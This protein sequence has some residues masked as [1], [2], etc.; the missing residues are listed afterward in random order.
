MSASNFAPS[1]AAML[2]HEGGF[3][4]N[5]NDPGG[6]TNQGVT[7]AVY[8]DWRS[9]KG[10]PQRSVRVIGAAE[11]ETIY[12]DL[13]WN[14]I[15]GDDLPSGVDYAVFDFAF[16]SGVGRAARFL[17]QAVGAVP[18]GQIG[19]ATLALVEIKQ[20]DQLIDALCDMRLNFLQ[21]LKTFQYFG[22]GWT[23]RVAE[24]RAKAKDMAA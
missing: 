24:V 17:Q 1:L 18:D 19:P 6:A 13:Y 12:R 21:A 23:R 3:V 15:R 9:S 5:P 8:D 22:R 10:L 14:R 2:V 11:V 20:A 4:C 7:Q 16:N